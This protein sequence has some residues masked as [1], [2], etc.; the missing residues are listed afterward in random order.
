MDRWKAPLYDKMSS[1]RKQNT[2]SFHVPG[3]KSGRGLDLD[4]VSGNLLKDVMSID[5]TEI[6]GLDDL[7]QPDGVIREAQELAA[8]CF[9]AEQ[10]FFLVNGSTV[11]NLAM[12]LALCDRDD[13][14]IVQRNVHKSVIHAL[15]LSGA[16]A[17]FLPPRR[18][19]RTGIATGID[20]HDVEAALNAYPEAKGVLITNP[21][22]YGFGVDVAAVAK[23][24]HKHRKPL[25][26]D[27]AHGAH[28][29]FHP[30]LPRSALSSGADVVVQ[31]THKMLSGLTMGA[32]LHVQGKLFPR[33]RLTQR[34][35]ML[36]SSSPSYPILASLDLCRRMMHTEGEQ[37]LNTG[38][39]VI[40]H[41]VLSMKEYAWFDINHS[42]EMTSTGQLHPAYETKDPFKIIICDRTGTLS[43]FALQNELEKHGC[44]MEMAD[45][46]NVLALFS[47]ASTKQDA[48]RLKDALLRISQQF[49][50]HQKEHLGGLTNI[51]KI[52][53]FNK[54]TSPISLD[55]NANYSTS[56][57]RINIRS[58]RLRDAVG[59]RAAEMVIPYP[60]GIP[61][62]FPGEPISAETAEYLQH[63]AASGAKFQGTEEAHLQTIQVFC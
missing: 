30:K 2:S 60:P 15:M 50:L 63:L 6:S 35:S 21:N 20:L 49:V 22:Y 16:K 54:V 40:Q 18:D 47:L 26:V 45:L 9:G 61:I 56:S 17:V 38:L 53:L 10:T 44:I 48:N 34:L 27:E 62:L 36:Q 12:I 11:G 7:H 55:I 46:Q 39:E 31:S 13:I 59:E 33:D 32:M 1:H 3:H 51:Y 41:F 4:P 23:R 52:P 57:E 42:F 14:I 24:V 29:G 8:E 37:R 28:F 25:L 5:F 19:T 58:V 43:G